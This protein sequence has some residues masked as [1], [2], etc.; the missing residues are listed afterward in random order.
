MSHLLVKQ[1][2][3]PVFDLSKL[4]P[5]LVRRCTLEM[6]SQQLCPCVAGCLRAEQRAECSEN[7]PRAEVSPEAAAF[8]EHEFLPAPFTSANEC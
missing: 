6:Q 1:F 2:S 7:L 3:I 8:L 5:K 4:Q